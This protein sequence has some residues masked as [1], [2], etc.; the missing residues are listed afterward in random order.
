MK[1]GYQ[2]IDLLN[3]FLECE[4]VNRRS[5]KS[6]SF[7]EDEISSVRLATLKALIAQKTKAC[8]EF[9]IEITEFGNNNELNF[10]KRKVEEWINEYL[11]WAN[12]NHG[13]NLLFPYEQKNQ[14]RPENYFWLLTS[15]LTHMLKTGYFSFGRSTIHLENYHIRTREQNI[16]ISI[17]SMISL[18]RNYVFLKITN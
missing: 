12:N 10:F 5:I 4:K 9:E 2:L 8:N 14:G 3:E 17:K 7:L 15:E 1:S 13:L 6:I 16:V 11:I 18:I